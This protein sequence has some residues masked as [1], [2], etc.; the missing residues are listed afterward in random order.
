MKI[1][2][3]FVLLFGVIGCR[4]ISTLH[5][6]PEG[7]NL[8]P[9]APTAEVYLTKSPEAPDC[10]VTKIA[11]VRVASK[12]YGGASRVNRALRDLARKKGGNAVMKYN[13]W[14]APNAGAWAAPHC[15]GTVVNADLACLKRHTLSVDSPATDPAA[16]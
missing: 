5:V 15:E 4:G 16:N 13:F 2:F 9:L 7:K 11:E 10:S 12:T 1:I 3:V 8:T 14:V 6:Y